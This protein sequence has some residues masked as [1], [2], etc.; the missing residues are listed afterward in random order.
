MSGGVVDV[1][2]FGLGLRT[3]H[4]EAILQHRPEVDWFEILTENYLVAGGKPLHYLERIR[5]HYPMVMHG[6]SL[7]I[8]S[9]AALDLDYLRA[10][11]LLAARIEASWISDHLCWN[12]VDGVNLHDLMP[13]PYTEEALQHVV[14]RVIQVQD[15]L[16]R[17]ILLEN[18]SSYVSYASAE[19][20]EWQFLAQLATAADC[21]LLLDINNIYVSSVNHGFDPLEF[22]CA[23]PQQRVRQ[24][25]LAGHQNHGTY[26][27]DTHD[28]P[29]ADPVWDLY[30]VARQRF[31]DVATMIERD[32]NIP[33]LGELLAELDLARN[34]AKAAQTAAA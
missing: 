32:D 7:S 16:G 1:Q 26:I 31:G 21:D 9:T 23:V 11:K 18:V 12:G 10:V 24:L 14:Q 4:Y 15:F 8:G 33:P 3:D 30:S 20:T 28:A 13:L 17:R 5:S 2:G 19:M 22:L 27:L 34:L 25:H 29:I 6:V